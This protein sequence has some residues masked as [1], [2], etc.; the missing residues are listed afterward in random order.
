[1]KFSSSVI[2]I[3]IWTKHKTHLSDSRESN[4]DQ[5]KDLNKFTTQIY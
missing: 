3:C 1:M 4:K 2:Q 5:N